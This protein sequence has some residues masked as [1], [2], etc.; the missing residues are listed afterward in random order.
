MITSL[1]T[2]FRFIPTWI[3]GDLDSARDEVL[4]YYQEK[5]PDECYIHA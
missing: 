3:C 2:P 1:C 5:V 4:K